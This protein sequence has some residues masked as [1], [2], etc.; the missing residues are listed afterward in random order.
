MFRINSK[1]YL[2]VFTIFVFGYCLRKYMN[3]CGDWCMDVK[4]HVVAKG[5]PGDLLSLMVVEDSVRLWAL[6]PYPHT[7]S[8]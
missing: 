3:F 7:T 4:E 1:R 6:P 2:N 5:N 8:Q